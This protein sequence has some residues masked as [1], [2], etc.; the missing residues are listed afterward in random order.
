MG[1]ESLTVL[2]QAYPVRKGTK[3]T[4]LAEMFV[5]KHPGLTE[6]IHSP[7]TALIYVEMLHCVHVTQFQT[8]S[9]W[10]QET[11]RL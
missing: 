2:G 10:Y 6:F 8:I 1:A 9:E 5:K 4:N 11:N 3:W 7:E